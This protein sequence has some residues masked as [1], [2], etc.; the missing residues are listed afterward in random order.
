MPVDQPL[1]FLLDDAADA[2]LEFR[3]FLTAAVK[4]LRNS[5]TSLRLIKGG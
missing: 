5:G 2:L 4:Q 1:F 3:M